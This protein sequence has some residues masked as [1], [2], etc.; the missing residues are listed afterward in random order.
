MA[1]IMLNE[2]MSYLLQDLKY[3]THEILNLELTD[4]HLQQF[5]K[6]TALLLAWNQKMNLTTITEPSEIMIKHFLDSLV[7][8]K[9]LDNRKSPNKLVLGDIGTGAGFPGIPIKILRPDINV[10]LI[11]SLKKRTFFLNEVINQLELNSINVIHS[12]AEDIGRDK[13]YRE[14][15]DIITA[16]AVAELPVLI[17]YAIPLLK[18]GGMLYA[19]KGIEPDK[20]ISAAQNALKL[21]NSK[22]EQLEQYRLTEDAAYRSLVIIRKTEKSSEKYPRQAG[23]PKKNPL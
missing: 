16:R 20:E 18:V 1:D 8:V 17:E 23:K 10:L 14:S 19:A 22:I 12:R 4:S 2:Q 15:F 3:K 11:D 9:W 13:L 6:Y 5:E 21:L 7:F